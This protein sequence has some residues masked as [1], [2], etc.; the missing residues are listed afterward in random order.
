[1]MMMFDQMFL[2]FLVVPQ[3]RK[4]T[5]KKRLATTTQKKDLSSLSLFLSQFKATLV[6]EKKKMKEKKEQ[7]DKHTKR[8]S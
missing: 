5:K 8:K 4:T 3:P 7:K 6:L 2:S 1:M